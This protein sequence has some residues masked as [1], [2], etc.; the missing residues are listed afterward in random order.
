M[1]VHLKERNYIIIEGVI[2]AGK[3]TLAK[4]L[5]HHLNTR[6]VLEKH[7]ENPFLIDFY[8]DPK[9]YAFQTEMY[10]LLSRYRQQLEEFSQTDLFERLIISD[11]HFIKNRIF[12]HITLEDR[13]Y[14]MYDMMYRVLERDVAVPDLVIYLQSTHERL[15]KNIK[16]RDRPYERNMNPD[17]IRSLVEAYNH[18]FLR[19]DASPILIVNATDMDFVHNQDHFRELMYQVLNSPDGT[20]Y[21]NPGYGDS[22]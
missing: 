3:T 5:S 9:H 17:Y 6:I 7:E 2:G 21:Y 12:A 14:S 18:Y 15:M 10:F 16:K 19:Y 11:Y 8:R 20:S 13:E 1:R 22:L 4:M